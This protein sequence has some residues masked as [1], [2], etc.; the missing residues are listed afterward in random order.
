[1]L[2]RSR[3]ERLSQTLDLKG[4]LLDAIPGRHQA[5]IDFLRLSPDFDENLDLCLRRVDID[6]QATV[7]EALRALSLRHLETRLEGVLEG[8]FNRVFAELSLNKVIG[9]TLAIGDVAQ[10][11]ATLRNRLKD[12]FNMLEID[13]FVVDHVFRGLI[14]DLPFADDSVRDFVDRLGRTGIG[15][16]IDG[17]IRFINANPAIVGVELLVDCDFPDDLPA[18]ARSLMKHWSDGIVI[19]WD[20]RDR[21]STR[22]NSSHRT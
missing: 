19:Q 14:A 11:V 5:L 7:R 20:N 18:L 10:R 16:F 6:R 15:L 1:M 21:K 2:F 17:L 9:G 3:N 22:L 8:Y 12:Y 4:L 13:D